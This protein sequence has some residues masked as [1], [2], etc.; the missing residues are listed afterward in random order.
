[1]PPA[2]DETREKRA[3]PIRY[4]AVGWLCT[5]SRLRPRDACIAHFRLASSRGG[6]FWLASLGYYTARL[7]TYFTLKR[8]RQA[9]V[10]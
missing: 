3:P 8:V 7:P 6:F 4:A 5:A 9:G 2:D 1:M 10:E